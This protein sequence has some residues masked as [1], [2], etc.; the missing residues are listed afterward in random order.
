MNIG[1]TV[2]TVNN[3]TNKVDSWIYNGTLRTPDAIL[4]QLVDCT[5]SCFIPFTCVFESREKAQAV[6]D[7]YK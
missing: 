2:Y 1:D 5:S 6:A 3:K 7:K 4:V